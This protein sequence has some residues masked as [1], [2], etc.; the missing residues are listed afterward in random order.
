MKLDS[1]TLEETG[2]EG[3]DW[4]YPTDV[5]VLKEAMKR[6]ATANA[7]DKNIDSGSS[8]GQGVGVVTGQEGRVVG[9]PESP[10][11][12]FSVKHPDAQP[13]LRQT[14][15]WRNY[16]VSDDVA[17]LFQKGQDLIERCV[18]RSGGMETYALPY[19]AGAR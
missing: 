2:F 16:P 8:E 9:T 5:G 4:V 12:V 7:A 3:T 15:S 11:G 13:G 6:Y 10:L 18:Y 17:M 19:F 1:N 14:A